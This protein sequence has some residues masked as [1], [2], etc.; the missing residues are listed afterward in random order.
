M[1][2]DTQ[3]A[4]LR[5]NEIRFDAHAGASYFSKGEHFVVVACGA[6]KRP[7]LMVLDHSEDGDGERC[8]GV[9]NSLR[10][11]L[12]ALRRATA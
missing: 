4:W 1:L 10:R 2:T 11:A 9:F 7:H 6:D 12:G 3:T 5:D 8:L